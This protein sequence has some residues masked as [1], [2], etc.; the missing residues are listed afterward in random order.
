MGPNKASFLKLK[1]GT[2]VKRLPFIPET[3]SALAEFVATKLD[4]PESGGDWHITYFDDEVEAVSVSDEMDY[5]SF[6]MWSHEAEVRVP[7]LWLTGSNDAPP[8]YEDAVSDANR[9][10]CVSWVGDSE[11]KR[12]SNMPVIPPLQSSRVFE[13]SAPSTAREGDGQRALLESQI[14]VLKQ[15]V[16]AM[17]SHKMHVPTTISQI[18][19]HSSQHSS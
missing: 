15:Q 11:I 8:S 14:E 12:P 5:Q 2:K 1:I 7:K 18:S 16:E 19:P 13:Y 9:T 4:K 3:Y 6:L 17:N 10:M